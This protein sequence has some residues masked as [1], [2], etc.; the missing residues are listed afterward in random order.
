MDSK[1]VSPTP[2]YYALNSE[3]G[4]IGLGVWIGLQPCLRI[5]WNAGK[6]ISTAHIFLFRIHFNILYIYGCPPRM[7]SGAGVGVKM[8]RGI[9]FLENKKV[10]RIY[11]LENR[12]VGRIYQIWFS[13]FYSYEIH[14]QA[15]WNVIYDKFS[16]FLSSA[17]H[18]WKTNRYSSIDI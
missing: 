1:V 16:I 8:L 6:A 13:Y 17:S 12:K 11:L 5:L 2:Q 10:C 14:I 18:I 9:S 7:W 15:F 4:K 3:P